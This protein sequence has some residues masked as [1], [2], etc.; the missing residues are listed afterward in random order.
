MSLHHSKIELSLTA[1]IPEEIIAARSPIG[2]AELALQVSG[3][4]DVVRRQDGLSYFPAIDYFRDH[5][6]FDQNLIR[7][8]DDL[9]WLSGQILREEIRARLRGIFSEV[10]VQTVQCLAFTLPSARPNQADALGALA[11]HYNPTKLRMVLSLSLLQKRPDIAG[12]ERYASHVV[13]RWLK[14]DF[15]DLQVN[16]TQQLA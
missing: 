3:Q 10:R 5:A 1:R 16:H 7:M 15:P 12:L 14:D 4:V 9:C 6:G 11:N 13:M 8:L 2:A